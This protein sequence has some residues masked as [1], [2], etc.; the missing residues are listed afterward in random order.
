LFGLPSNGQTKPL[1][2]AALLKTTKVHY[3]TTEGTVHD[4]SRLDPGANDVGEAGWGGLTQFSGDVGEV[5]SRVV[6][7]HESQI[8]PTLPNLN[9]ES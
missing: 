3:F 1:A 5:V 2:E 4:I 9:L 8:E 6:R 7:R